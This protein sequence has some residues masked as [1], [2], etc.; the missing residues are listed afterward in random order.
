MSAADGLWRDA[1]VDD[2]GGRPH[3]RA[4]LAA[5]ARP[6]AQTQP[7]HVPRK[8]TL[9]MRRQS[10]RVFLAMA[11]EY[12]T[13]GRALPATTADCPA[14]RPCPYVSCG[15]HL[16]GDGDPRTGNIRVGFPGPD[17]E[18]DLDAMP[19]TCTLDVAARGGMTLEEVGDVLNLTRER[20][21]Q[22]ERRATE[23][24]F[25]GPLTRALAG[26]ETVRACGESADST[27]ASGAR[28]DRDALD[29]L[30]DVASLREYAPADDGDP[31]EA[32]PLWGVP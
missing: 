31:M 17:G 32:S 5:E 16:A 3:V 11:A 18:P 1:M 22:I 24:L 30:D 28:S 2:G 7:P 25:Y 23:D 29:T 8:R 27:D 26:I 14:V 10:K 20:T 6:T 13:T 9:S 4:H 19:E 12:P 21:R 15:L